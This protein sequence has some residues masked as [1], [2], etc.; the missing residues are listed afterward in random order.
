MQ[1]LLYAAGP[2]PFAIVA[3]GGLSLGFFAWFAAVSH[4]RALLNV[5]E[6]LLLAAI[7]AGPIVALA[8]W[9]W[10]A[11]YLV[12]RTGISHRS[13]L[14]LDAWS[15]APFYLLWIP[16][17]LLPVHVISE[18][19]VAIAV[20]ALWGALKLTA[21]VRLNQTVREVTVTYLVTRIPLIIIALLGA[22]LIGQRAG[23]HWAASHDLLLTVWGRWDAQHYIEIAAHGYQGTN[24]AFFPLYPLLLAGLGKFTGS[25][26]VAGLIVSN[27]ALY[28]GLLFFYKLV[29]HE[30]RDRRVAYRAI[31]Y[32]SIFPT[33]IFFSA[34]YTESL[35]FALT[36]ASFYYIREHK[37]LLAGFI[38]A[39]ASATRIEG[40]LLFVPFAIEWWAAHRTGERISWRSV[41]GICLVPSGLLA[42]MGY[43]WVLVGDPLYFSHVQVHWHRHLAAP[44]VSIWNGFHLISSAHAAQTISYQ[45]LE[46]VFTAFMLVMLALAFRTLRWSYWVYMLLSTVVPLSTSSLMSMP[47]FALVLFPIFML[48]AIW[49]KRPAVNNAVVAFSLPLLGLFTVLFADWYWIA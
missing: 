8:A 3:G 30:V 16:L 33:A 39:L 36:V 26:L 29:E 49:G 47:R 17:L 25:H 11:E 35:F 28:V 20:P 43:L 21:A 15:F 24:M 2:A 37:W 32:I 27:V 46:L 23:T 13:A 19:P 12:W 40:A 10:Y 31:F 22:T 48:L 34:V 38:G 5:T 7:A 6:V 45:S 1:G 44:W 18:G 41:L 42:Y 9:R 4:V 14:I